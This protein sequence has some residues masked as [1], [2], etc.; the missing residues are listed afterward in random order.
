MTKWVHSDVQDNGLNNI[1]NNCNK[2]ALIS[3]Y[4][5][6]DSY[7]TVNGLILAEATMASGDFTLA[8]SAGAARTLTTAAGKQD[9]S[10]NASSTVYDTGTATSGAAT[11]LTN[12]G[13][14]Y[15][16]D[17]H[18]NRALVITAGTGS[19]QHRVIASNTATAL[20]V[21]AAWDTNPD[22]TSVYK[23]VDDLH[24]AFLDTVNTKVLWVT[25]ETSD[26]T[27]TA[28]NPVTFP[29]LVYTANQPT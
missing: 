23:I 1:K 29:S 28:T 3:G 5:A 12:T 13:K 15:T 19:G 17:E 9:A 24:L 7:A 8:G 25:D 27:I 21:S 26:Q 4:A 2:L 18:A 11:S 22:A 10:A 14:A 20:T 16:T 6:N